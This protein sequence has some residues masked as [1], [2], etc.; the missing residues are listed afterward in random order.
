MGS[1]GSGWALVND[2]YC[3]GTGVVGWGG[4]GVQGEL[5]VEDTPIHTR[6]CQ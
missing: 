6:L 4:G 5:G 3:I 2:G 1:W